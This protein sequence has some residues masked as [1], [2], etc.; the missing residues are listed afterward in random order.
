VDS[1]IFQV[2]FE[3]I[4]DVE[5]FTNKFEKKR[6]RVFQQNKELVKYPGSVALKKRRLLLQEGQGLKRRR[7]TS[8]AICCSLSIS[9]KQGVVV[10]RKVLRKINKYYCLLVC[11][12]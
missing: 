5:W 4:R 8:R 2:I 6:M 10:K 7:L 3:I 9:L 11:A 12:N 1:A